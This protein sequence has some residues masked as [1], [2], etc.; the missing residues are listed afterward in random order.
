MEN[1]STA[2]DSAQVCQSHGWR[3]DIATGKLAG[4]T[5]IGCLH[6][7]CRFGEIMVAVD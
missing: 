7:R 2:S 1:R 5:T 6:I 3:Y 4:A